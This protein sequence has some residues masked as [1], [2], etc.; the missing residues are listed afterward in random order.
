MIELSIVVPV[1]N[2]KTEYLQKCF[3]SLSMQS[4]KGIEFVIVDDGSEKQCSELCDFFASYENRARV[5]HQKN[6]GVSV[7]RNTGLENARG[8]YLIFV[9]ADDSLVND[10]CE[11]LCEIM[12]SSGYDIVFFKYAN[13]SKGTSVPL[14]ST[15]IY[16]DAFHVE[17]TEELCRD[18]ISRSP[19]K[20]N[21]ALG[22][23]WGKIFKR[24][25]IEASGIRFV[26][27]LKKAQDR[28]FMLDALIRS[29]RV[30]FSSIVAYCYN[31]LNSTSVCHRFIPDILTTLEM[32]DAQMVRIIN[33]CA[34]NPEDFKLEINIMRLQNL[35]EYLHLYEFHLDNQ[36]SKKAKAY[37]LKALINKNIYS[38]ALKNVGTG[39][40]KSLDRQRKIKLYILKRGWID[41]YVAL[42]TLGKK[43]KRYF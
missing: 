37:R 30:A 6:A 14:N 20:N 24:S 43:L 34:P 19:D 27:G 28:V 11:E 10:S 15:E 21:Y 41:L 8:D 1:Y 32:V 18:I 4:M 16:I 38:V 22:A 35:L 40:L 9:D 23:P 33:E 12:R 3:N 26:E 42:S 36:D 13:E 17:R 7:A 29:P 5:I 25:F 31:D 2:I 39:D